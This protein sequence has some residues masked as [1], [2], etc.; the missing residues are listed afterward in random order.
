MGSARDSRAALGAW[1]RRGDGPFAPWAAE[2]ALRATKRRHG[3][4]PHDGLQPHSSPRPKAVRYGRR[5]EAPAARGICSVGCGTRPVGSDSPRPLHKRPIHRAWP[6]ACPKRKAVRYGRCSEAPAAPGVPAPETAEL[7]LRDPT[8][9]ELRANTPCVELGRLRVSKGGHN[10]FL[11]R[12]IRRQMKG[13]KI[14][15][16]ASS[17]F[18][19]G[20]TMV[21]ARLMKLPWIMFCR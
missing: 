4:Q 19:P 3:S 9:L 17:I 7:S 14:S 21:L 1:K 5:S 2:L 16:I 13:V 12:S 6:R 18:P 15:C 8:V 20:T 10:S 11:R